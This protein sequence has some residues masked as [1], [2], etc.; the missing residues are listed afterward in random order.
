M[1]QQPT[2]PT[3]PPSMGDFH[4]P[5]EPPAWPKVVGIISIVLSS[6]G[7]VCG[8][9]GIGFLAF[10]RPLL[11][12]AE[13]QMG[14]APEVLI[15]GPLL[16]ALAAVGVVWS[17]VLLVAGIATLR[18]RPNGRML[19]V[20]YSGV[21]IVLTVISSFVNWQH[22]SA[23]LKW[24]SENPTDQWAKQQSPMG[25]YAG[26]AFGVCIGLGYPI[27]LLVWFGAMGKR[28]EAGSLPEEPLV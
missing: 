9:C 12:M 1:S 26:M 21:A 11:K 3:I 15:P 19:H 6:L 24:V 22:Q 23:I 27:F 16:V 28:P 10:M 18:R 13:A 8:V 5:V 2:N 20:V 14:P 4:V 7:L 25:A 17:A